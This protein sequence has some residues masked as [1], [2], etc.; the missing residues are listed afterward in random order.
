MKRSDHHIVQ[1]ILD[2]EVSKEAFDGFQD[3][4]RENPDLVRLYGDYANLHH[5]LFEEYEDSPVTDRPIVRS[6]RGISGRIFWIAV[7][8]AAVVMILV[9]SRRQTP[10]TASPP[11]LMAD[12]RFTPDAIWRVD[13]ISRVE[14][15]LTKM[16]KGATLRLK[17]GQ[18]EVLSDSSVTVILDGPAELTLVSEKALRL[19]VGRG[20]FTIQHSKGTLEVSTPSMTV[21]DLGTEFGIEVHPDR[22]DELHV[23][24]G[25]VKMRVNGNAD[26][27]VLSAGEAGRIKGTAAIKRFQANEGRFPGKLMEFKPV[28]AGRF[29]NADWHRDYG[30]P[31]I[32]EDRIEGENYSLFLKLP[33]PTT[34]ST[35]VLAT[36]KVDRPAAGEFH[37]DGWAGMSFFGQG[38]EWLFYGDSFGPEKTWSLDVKQG[39]PVILP[40]T[41]LTGPH[42]VTLRY[43]A[44]S[45]DVSLHE[46]G[47]PLGP[48]FCSGK[49][50]AGASFDEIRI[51]ASSSAA[52]AV[53]GLTIRSGDEGQ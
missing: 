31:T 46:G 6:E 11:H 40:A 9:V 42:T 28:V 22:P 12:V 23:F 25:K 29:V 14:G 34:A 15:G 30:N 21:E 18:A 52:L 41:P 13:G 17:Q 3:Q 35:V 44:R 10:A 38:H 48:P 39:I 4:M 49:I 26:G 36:L 16:G 19:G 53:G 47:L 2:G 8:A 50:P 5:S 43:D 33:E 20:R 7:A 1:Q 37:S 27:E 45:G 51:G 32:T 24:G